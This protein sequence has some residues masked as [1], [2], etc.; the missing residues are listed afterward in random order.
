MLLV[1][2]LK[3]PLKGQQIGISLNVAGSQSVFFSLLE[4]VHPL[5]MPQYPNLTPLGL[6]SMRKSCFKLFLQQRFDYEGCM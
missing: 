3:V 5:A 4:H 1:N 6:E 2:I